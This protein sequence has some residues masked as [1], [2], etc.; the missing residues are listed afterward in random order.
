MRQDTKPGPRASGSMED[1]GQHAGVSEELQSSMQ[2]ETL[3]DVTV[4][5]Q[6]Y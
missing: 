4:G 3:V 1:R 2:R 5:D 6:T